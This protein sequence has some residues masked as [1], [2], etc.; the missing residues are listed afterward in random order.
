MW[1]WGGNV[2]KERNC[3]DVGRK[4]GGPYHLSCDQGILICFFNIKFL[5]SLGVQ[6]SGRAL[7]YNTQGPG[8]SPQF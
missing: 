3:I 8:F 7:A 5:I 2:A 4:G 1:G 6:F